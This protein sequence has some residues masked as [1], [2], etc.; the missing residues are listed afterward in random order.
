MPW[1]D[2]LCGYRTHCWGLY[3][4]FLLPREMWDERKDHWSSQ[5]VP[6]VMNLP[7]NA[8]DARDV[9]L[10]PGWGRSPGAGRGNCSILVWRIPWPEESRGLRS[11]GLQRAGH[12][13]SKLACTQWTIG[14]VGVEENLF[15]FFSS[16]DIWTPMLEPNVLLTHRATGRTEEKMDLRRVIINKTESRRE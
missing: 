14:L 4:Q 10:V 9:A 6:V 12:D 3:L 2:D 13:W 1:D 15:L 7:A 16:S 5:V 8:G 11:T